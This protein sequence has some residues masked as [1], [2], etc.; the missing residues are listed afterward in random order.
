LSYSLDHTNRHITHMLNGR[1]LERN[2][3][4]GLTAFAADFDS[5]SVQLCGSLLPNITAGFKGETVF[6]YLLILTANYLPLWG[7]NSLFF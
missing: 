5:F 2:T 4:N 7:T 6:F 3:N 1:F